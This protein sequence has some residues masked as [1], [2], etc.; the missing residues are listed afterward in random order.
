[1]KKE[2]IIVRKRYL[3]REK[4][5]L[6]LK[7]GA[8]LLLTVFSAVIFASAFTANATEDHGRMKY[9]TSVMVT[10]GD[11]LWSI[12]DTYMTSDYENRNAYMHELCTLNHLMPDAMIHEGQYIVVPYFDTEE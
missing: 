6:L 9:Y 8:I 2:T 7:I 1:M 12:A 10:D 11:S 4:R 5:R 3:K